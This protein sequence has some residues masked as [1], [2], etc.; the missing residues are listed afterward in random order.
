M[1][2]IHLHAFE[3]CLDTLF[4]NGTATEQEDKVFFLED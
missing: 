4:V 3:P 1:R 2:T